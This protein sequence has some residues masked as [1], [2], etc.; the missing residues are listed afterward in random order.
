M[1]VY[2]VTV[3]VNANICGSCLLANHLPWCPTGALWRGRGQREGRGTRGRAVFP[4]WLPYTVSPHLG[5]AAVLG[6]G[7]RACRQPLG[8]VPGRAAW[9]GSPALAIPP[10]HPPG[11]TLLSAASP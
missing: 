11:L 5:E 4:L 10:L 3:Q 7:E 9:P 2:A 8:A 1:L 6:E